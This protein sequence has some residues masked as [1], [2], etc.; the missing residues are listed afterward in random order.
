M[1]KLL[2]A[3]R[4]ALLAAFAVTLTSCGLYFGDSNDNDSWTYCGSDGY[5]ECSG[6]D[7]SFVSSQCPAGTQ[8]PGFTCETD[9]DCAAGCYCDETGTAGPA[10]TCVEAGFCATDEDCP[11]GHV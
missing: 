4:L 3:L 5:Y 2:S 9:A 11:A 1:T 7:C 6:E 10:N 8:T